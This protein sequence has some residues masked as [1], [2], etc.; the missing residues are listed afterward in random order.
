MASKPIRTDLDFESVSRIINLPD[1]SSAQH[2]ATKAQLDLKAPLA[3]PTFTGTVTV[4]DASFG[5]AKLDNGAAVSVLGR[6]ANSS[7]VRADIAAGA[8]DQI[9]ARQSNALAFVALAYAMIASGAI[10]TA[11]EYQAATASK[12][13]NAANVWSAA[14][15]TALTDGTNIAVDFATG[16]NF[17]GASNA[18]LGLGGNRTLSAPSNLKTGQYGVLW[19]GAV[20]STRTLTLN[21]AWELMDGIEAGPYSITTAQIL[22]VAYALRDTKSYV[23]AILRRAA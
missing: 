23:T 20:T 21:A 7:G 22:G 9:L 11:G 6:S 18:V 8:N 2:P 5:P 16:I 17:G 13:L 19:F 14:G 3:S 4:P 12:L 15:L 1:A 10:A